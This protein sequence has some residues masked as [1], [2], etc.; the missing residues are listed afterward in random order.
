M[1]SLCKGRQR[2]GEYRVELLRVLEHREMTNVGE[3]DRLDTVLAQRVE[4]VGAMP[5]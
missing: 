3:H 2:R 1:G 5:G 4:S